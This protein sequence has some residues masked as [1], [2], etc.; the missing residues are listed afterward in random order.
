VQ[1]LPKLGPIRFQFSPDGRTFTGSTQGLVLWET[2]TGRERLRTG[3][4]ASFQDAAFSPDGRLLAAGALDGAVFVFDAADGTELAKLEGHTGSVR[5]LAF[6]PDGN[7]LATGSADTTV[8]LWD[9]TRWPRAKPAA[10][11]ADPA[12]LWDDLASPDAARAYKAIRALAAAPQ[13]SVPL[14]K[15]KVPPVRP[16]PR[17]TIARLIADLDSDDFATRQKATQELEAIG[18]PAESALTTALDHDGSLEMKKRLRNLLEKL[19]SD[20]LPP[21][22]LRQMRVVEV[23][24]H[25][26][27]PEARALLQELAAGADGA[28]LTREAQ[29]A[30]RLR[31][32]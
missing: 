8:L 3:K 30:L 19:S 15:E 12:A 2:V 10:T 13:K 22:R 32:R 6:S 9:A 7:L 27:S 11:D 25:A 5:S 29:A 28:A 20:D 4:T 24:Q 17:E 23:L 18:P 1:K 26:Q 14:L 31:P 21:E 16:V